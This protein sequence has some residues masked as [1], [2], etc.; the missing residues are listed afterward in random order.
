[1]GG[2][3]PPLKFGYSF[4]ILA[5]GEILLQQKPIERGRLVTGIRKIGKKHAT[6]KPVSLRRALAPEVA[7]CG[8]STTA[9]RFA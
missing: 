9:A 8:S 5:L 1:V 3:P 6:I 2:R 4:R 7:S